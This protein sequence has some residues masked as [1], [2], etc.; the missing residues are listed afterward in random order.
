MPESMFCVNHP[1][2]QTLLRCGKCGLPICT[3]CA[4]RH[5]VGL[6]CPDCAQLRKVPTYVVPTSY[7]LRAL[8]ASLGAAFLAG[9]IA[10]ILPLFLP[11]FFLN[12]F[13]ALAAGAFVGEAASRVTGGKRGRGLQI[14]AGISVILGSVGATLVVSVVGFG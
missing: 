2:R 9:V 5:P 6:R 4:I 14:V 7:Y 3:Q 12:F 1:D 10:Q 13:M 11:V 8:G